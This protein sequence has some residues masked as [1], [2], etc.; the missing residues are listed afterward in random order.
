MKVSAI[1]TTALL[2]KS[3]SL[4]QDASTLKSIRVPDSETAVRIAE[5]ALIPVYGKKQIESERPF[6][7]RLNGDVWTVAGSLH[8]PD[9]KGGVTS[10]CAG[11]VALVRISRTSG[12]VL[13]MEHGK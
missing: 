9:G 2:L 10:D 5:K 4:A 1:F 3:L 7:A 13:H 6:N 12:H 8:C 11:G